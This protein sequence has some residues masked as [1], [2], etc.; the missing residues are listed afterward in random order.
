MKWG[1]CTWLWSVG[2]VLAAL[3]WSA[4]SSQPSLT[5]KDRSGAGSDYGATASTGGMFVP[6]KPKKSPTKLYAEANV[7]KSYI[8]KGRHGRKVTRRMNPRYI[9]IHSTQN[10]S[11]SAD[12]WRHSLALNNGK[13]RARKRRGG[14]RIGYLTWHYSVDQYRCVQHL[15][16]NEQGEHADFDGPGNNYSI[17]IEMCENRGNSRRATLERTA[18]LTAWLMYK[19]NIPLRKVVPHYHWRRKGLAVEHKNCPHF[20]L[21]NGHPGAKWQAYLAK[22]N[23]YHK[24][25]TGGTPVAAPRTTSSS[26][27]KTVP[28][29]SSSTSPTTS[30]S[31][32]S[33]TSQSL[34]KG[35]T[36]TSSKPKTVSTRSSSSSRSSS[37]Y[38][39][40][41]K[42]DTLYGLSRRYKTS[43]SAIQRANG[44]S[45]TM[46][47]I[48]K[49]LKIPAS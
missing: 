49:K 2:A 32:A 33:H 11:P 38:H 18:K 23:K 21:D 30:R 35:V 8:P 31:T 1:N 42:G 47:G 5:K 20:L 28:R 4:C 44:M 3:T 34:P 39:T 37:R 15:P 40:V 13:L 7:K 36:R 6:S 25:I 29:P 14:N 45:G 26:V 10:Y 27:V 46:I 24:S 19:H 22:I 12:A 41:K 43:V 16:T 9:T 17:G 48:G